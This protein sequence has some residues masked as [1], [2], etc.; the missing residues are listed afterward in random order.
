MV[1]RLLGVELKCHFL[2]FKIALPLGQHFCPFF[3]F[4]M[5]KSDTEFKDR[6]PSWSIVKG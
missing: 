2:I 3:S 6:A 1:D 5:R 4:L